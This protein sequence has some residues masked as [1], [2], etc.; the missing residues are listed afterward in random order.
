MN[1]ELENVSFN[2]GSTRAL[3]G[4]TLTFDPRITAI[5]GPN[6]AG[7]STLIKC[8]AGILQCTGT[9]SFNGSPLTAAT[10]Q[11]YIE[12]MSY[13]PQSLPTQSQLTVFEAVLLGML[14]T[15]S[16]TVSPEQIEKVYAVLHDLGLEALA[17]RKLCELSGGQQ[18]MVSIAQSII[19]DPRIFL[20]DE[21]LNS[22]D[23]YHQ[24]EVINTI[25][26]ITQS[27]DTVT[28][29][30]IHDLNLAARYAKHVV[31]LKDGELYCCG[32][33]AEVL[34][35]ETIRDVYRVDAEVRIDASGIPVINMLGIAT[36]NGPRENV[37]HG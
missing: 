26:A 4:I 18:Q 29:I 15:L 35:E 28:V 36:A 16:L 10:R 20:L 31:I 9:I 3:K 33:P 30:A 19:K 22:L 12:S 7:K 32:T 21:P 24:F 8:L 5:L 25:R 34:T 2:Y 1:L 11:H 14:T 6:G 13:L 37:I 27:S 23:I 17:E